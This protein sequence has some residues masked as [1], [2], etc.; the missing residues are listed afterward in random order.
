MALLNV[1][2]IAEKLGFSESWVRKMVDAD[3]IP[4]IRLGGGLRFD[5]AAIDDW[6]GANTHGPKG[7]K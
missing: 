2:Q 7:E 6:V 4:H 5:E 3:A 1:G